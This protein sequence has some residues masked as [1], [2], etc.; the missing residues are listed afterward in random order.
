MTGSCM[1]GAG[2]K[3]LCDD[4]FRAQRELATRAVR[5]CHNHTLCVLL[6]V[7]CCDTLLSCPALHSASVKMT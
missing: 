4:A 2:H 7:V 1:G 3:R 6:W 5:H